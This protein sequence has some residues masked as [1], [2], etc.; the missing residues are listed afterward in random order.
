MAG[1]RGAPGVRRN[2]AGRVGR[3]G[4][5]A[6]AVLAA[7]CGAEPSVGLPRPLP[8]LSGRHPVIMIMIDTL[9]ADHTSLHGHDRDTTPFLSE[10]AHDS[11]V[12]GRAYSTASWTRPSVASLFTSRLPE[13]HGCEG[14]DG[15]LAPSLTTLP[16]VFQAAGFT[17]L[18]VIA[19]GNVLGKY[20]FGQGFDSYEFHKD[21][22]HNPYADAAKLRAPVQEALGRV[23]AGPFFLYLHYVDPHD[24]YR[25][26]PEFDF[27]PGYSGPMDGSREA[28]DPWFATRPPEPELQRAR[29]LYDGEI[30]WYDARLRELC[31]RLD[32]IG[33]LDESWLVITSDHGEGLWTHKVQ[34]HGQEVFE[35]QIRV[36]LIVRPPGGLDRHVWIE[37][38][39]SQI[40]LGPTLLELMGLEVPAGFQGRSWAGYLQ[41]R[42]AAP[43]RPVIVDEVV[44]DFE[45]AAIVDGDAKLIVDYRRRMKWVFD[46]A[47]NPAEDLALAA[48]MNQEFSLEGQRL[49]ALLAAELAEAR[50]HRPRDTQG[51][52][53]DDPEMLEMLRQMGYLGGGD[54]RRA[55]DGDD[56]T[57][58][59]DGGDG[60]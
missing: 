10:L 53:E 23:G 37:E 20:G 14:R 35:E 4:A 52:L 16:E 39:V 17:T 26:H 31:G 22:P 51:V 40:D 33:L 29:D 8:D 27:S 56:A 34:S 7:A 1:S 9:R 18:G 30:A 15:N 6:L 60:R 49:D 50:R 13:A 11:I 36:P 3:A 42:E 58:N 47:T 38:P 41:G 43:T 32:Q 2:R 24:P 21:F 57:T 25:H 45:L 55:P 46:L 28:L 5:L 44:D 54:E 19:N 48:D 12:F 59:D